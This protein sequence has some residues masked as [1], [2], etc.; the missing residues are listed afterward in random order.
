[1]P[2]LS[3]SAYEGAAAAATVSAV[4]STTTTQSRHWRGNNI[5][6]E[7]NEDLSKMSIKFE[8]PTS[9]SSLP[10]KMEPDTST[11]SS[12]LVDFMASLTS[13]QPP[14]NPAIMCAD[15]NGSSEETIIFP[16][17]NTA[18]VINSADL[19]L[20]PF[21]FHENS[22]TTTR[23]SDGDELEDV[24]KPSKIFEIFRSL[25]NVQDSKRCSS[26]WKHD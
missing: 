26:S 15:S 22:E 24:R 25:S 3:C 23:S 5:K 21:Q 10:L 7:D 18:A 20:P 12:H 13:L 9:T 14:I 2:P 6:M 4:S 16:S 19:N 17:T 11:N 1:M 8:F